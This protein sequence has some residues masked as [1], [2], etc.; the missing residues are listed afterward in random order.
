MLIWGSENNFQRPGFRQ[1]KPKKSCKIIRK[2]A[3]FFRKIWSGGKALK[4]CSRAANMLPTASLERSTRLRHQIALLEFFEKSTFWRFFIRILPGPKIW[5]FLKK[6]KKSVFASLQKRPPKIQNR[7]LSNYAG[8]K[9]V[10]I[11]VFCICFSV[12]LRQMPK[13]GAAKTGFLSFKV[14][15]HKNCRPIFLYDFWLLPKEP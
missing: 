12:W 8:Q 7:H 1:P 14:D 9:R 6:P 3:Q 2:Y 5:H 15:A 4:T 10:E 11:S 13:F